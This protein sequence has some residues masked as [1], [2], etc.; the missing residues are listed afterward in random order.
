M[1]YAVTSGLKFDLG[2]LCRKNLRNG[3]QWKKVH[4]VIGKGKGKQSPHR[5]ITQSVP[6]V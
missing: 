5:P 1:F 3:D 2:F 6:G 4:V